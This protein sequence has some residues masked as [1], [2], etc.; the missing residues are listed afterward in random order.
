MASRNWATTDSAPLV[1][2]R[3]LSHRDIPALLAF[4][5]TSEPPSDLPGYA[6]LDAKEREDWIRQM[7]HRGFN[8]TAEEGGRCVAHLVL[9]RVGDTAQMSVFVHP[10][11][12]GRGIGSSLLRVALDQARDMGLRHV[13]IAANADDESVAGKLLHAGFRKGNCTGNTQEFIL[14]L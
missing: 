6:P 2:I 7:M 12:R 9:I 8:F 10:T 1:A 4:Y 5:E 11:F 13:W 3:E 14:P